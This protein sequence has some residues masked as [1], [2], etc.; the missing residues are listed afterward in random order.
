MDDPG[1]VDLEQLVADL[2]QGDLVRQ[3]L[4]RIDLPGGLESLHSS[5]PGAFENV[6]AKLCELGLREGILDELDEKLL[7]F[8]EQLA[9]WSQRWAPSLLASCLNW[10][11]YDDEAILA[12]L[13]ERLGAMHELARSGEYDIYID[14]DTFG[15]FPSAFRKRPL[16][17]PEFY[18]VL[19]SIWDIYALAHWPEALRNDENDQRIDTVI[20]YISH[21]DYQA[22]AEGYGVM[23]AGKRRYYSM[24]WS[25]HLP[26]YA[27]SAGTDEQR[28]AFDRPMHEHMYVQRLELMA[29]FRLARQS[30]WFQEGLRHLEGL[31]TQE[32]TYRF[33]ARYLREGSSGYWVLGAYMRLEENRRVRRSLDLDS[34]FRMRKIE[35]LVQEKG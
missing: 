17:N 7:P 9:N 27:A 25:V 19:P 22:L 28:P 30:A 6:C 11:G 5:K 32:G 3:W 33:P 23:R 18:D 8:R 34:T 14:R 4:D 10:V 12:C 13:S 2:L 35:R 29:H 26:G 15:D 1:D 20:A 24:G 31:R 21:P 16:V